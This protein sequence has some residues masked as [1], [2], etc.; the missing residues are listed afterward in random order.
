M[1]FLIAKLLIPFNVGHWFY[2]F[3]QLRLQMNDTVEL[4]AP[5]IAVRGD[6]LITHSARGLVLSEDRA[7]VNGHLAHSV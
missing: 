2:D 6:V 5:Q 3:M 1:Y 4:W 7:T